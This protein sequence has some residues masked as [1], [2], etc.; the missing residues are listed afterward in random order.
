M[1]TRTWR[2]S[3][4]L[5]TTLRQAQISGDIIKARAR[6]Q[7][8]LSDPHVPVAVTEI[9]PG[10]VITGRVVGNGLADELRDKRYLLLQTR[11]RLLH[12]PHTIAVQ[13][14]H[15]PRPHHT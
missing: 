13:S 12:F 5:E 2:L 15:R 3:P 9:K 10:T 1:W 8:R 7:A 11:A 14:A 4:Q 6:H